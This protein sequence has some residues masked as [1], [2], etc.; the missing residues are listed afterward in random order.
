MESKYKITFFWD[1]EARVWVAT[2]DD[3][4]G[5]VLEHASLDAL[6]ENVRLAVPELL[7]IEDKLHGDIYIN[8]FVSRNE[9][10]HV[11]G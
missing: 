1:D 8:Y 4:R 6:M 7:E 10:V 11:S 3:I 9:L 2:G 5:L